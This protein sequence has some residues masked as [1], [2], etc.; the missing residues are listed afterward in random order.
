ME[1]KETT[2]IFDAGIR[3]S[4]GARGGTTAAAVPTVP[5]VAAAAA[6]APGPSAWAIWQLPDSIEKVM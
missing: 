4:S 5:T 2:E 6:P 3:S 1:K